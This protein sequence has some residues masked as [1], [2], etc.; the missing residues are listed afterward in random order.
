MSIFSAVVKTACEKANS[1]IYNRD[2]KSAQKKAYKS[3]CK[4]ANGKYDKNWQSNYRNAL[5]TNTQKAKE[6]KE[7]RSTFINNI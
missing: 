1:S 6:R 3:A 4:K 7:L 2:I 5:K